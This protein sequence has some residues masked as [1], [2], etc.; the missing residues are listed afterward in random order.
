[1]QKTTDGVT[2]DVIIDWYFAEASANMP[3]DHG[4][5]VPVRLDVIEYSKLTTFSDVLNY[6]NNTLTLLNYMAT[7]TV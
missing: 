3:Y 6:G 1:M 2:K 5:T 4:K 7:S